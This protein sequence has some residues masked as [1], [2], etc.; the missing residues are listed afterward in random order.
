MHGD[1]GLTADLP[2]RLKA[3]HVPDVC[4]A[5]QQGIEVIAMKRKEGAICQRL[6]IG[7]AHILHGT[8][9]IK[10]GTDYDS[11]SS[12]SILSS[13]DMPDALT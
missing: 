3:P 12:S 7:C 11:K 6:H 10:S 4:E 9:V 2:Q 8:M 13:T 5:S 1:D